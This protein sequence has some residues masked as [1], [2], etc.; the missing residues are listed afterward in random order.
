M[1]ARSR[2][3]FLNALPYLDQRP[4]VLVLHCPFA[5]DLVKPPS[6]TA[7]SHALILQVALATLVA[8]GTIQRMI[9][10]QELHHTF[11]RLVRERAIRLDHHTRLHRPRARGDWLRRP[12]DLYQAHSAVSGNHEFL[13][14][15]VPGDRDARLLACLDER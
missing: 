2:P 4:D 5:R 8:D 14:V 10:Q 1:L 9:C 3:S 15:A 11:S 13:V 7:I 12:L 6:V